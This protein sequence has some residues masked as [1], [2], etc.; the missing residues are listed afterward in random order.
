MFISAG[1]ME[2]ALKSKVALGMILLASVLTACDHD[3]LTAQ[4]CW[5]RCQGIACAC[6]AAPRS[7]TLHQRRQAEVDKPFDP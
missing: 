2:G 5:N 3:G 7:Q 4:P 6:F 1:M